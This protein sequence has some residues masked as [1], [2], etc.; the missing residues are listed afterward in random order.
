M[1]KK[2]VAAK[3]N[4]NDEELLSDLKSRLGLAERFSRERN[5]L[6]KKWIKDY[7]LE[8]IQEASIVD[9]SN[10]IHIPYIFSTIE[11]GLPTIFERIPTIILTQ[12]GKM[13][14]EF[15]EFASKI[16]NYLNEKLRLEEEIENVGTMFKLIGMGQLKYGWEIK[17]TTVTQ[18]EQTFIQTEEGT[19]PQTVYNE[20]QVP[21]KNLPFVKSVNYSSIFYS[22]ESVFTTDDEENEI[23]YIICR[24][25]KTQEEIEQQYEVKLNDED[26]ELLNLQEISPELANDS[27]LKE[28]SEGDLKRGVIY[29]YYGLLSKK[30]TDDPDWEADKNYYLVYNKNKILKK[31]EAMFKKPFLLIGNYGIPTEF[32]KFGEAKVLRELEQDVS[33]GRSRMMDIRDKYG[34]KVAI[35]EG[36]QVDEAALKRPADFTIMRFSGNQI[37]V[38]VTPPPIPEALLIALEQSRTDLQMASAQLDI[39]RGGQQST[40]KTAT[41]QT[42]FAQAAEKR[43]NRQK[44]KIGNLIKALAR[45]LLQLC[46][47]NWDEEELVKITDI[48]IEEIQQKS[49][50]EKLK[51]VGSLYDISIDQESVS[52]NRET[53]AAQAIA[54]YREVKD[55]PLVNR[56][57][58]LKEALKVGFG[59]QDFDRF[60]NTTLTPEQ[61]LQAVQTLIQMGLIPPELLQTIA[62]ALMGQQQEAEGQI[63]R[64]AEQT[65]TQITEKAMPGASQTQ[66]TSQ[67]R[68]SYKQ[69]GVPKGAQLP[70][71]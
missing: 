6:V 53:I 5:K 7:K 16:W 45:N 18:E 29:E 11:S 50:L 43:L 3:K 65:P 58:V 71:I 10:K 46:G 39:S 2:R 21:V 51:K 8:T 36:T 40:V 48:P 60:L 68:A 26:L 22:P 17:T 47:E 70:K 34:T 54:L 64:P 19:I 63:G 27:I 15:T 59:V 31:P 37:P 38:Y 42:I 23:P 33:L 66:I 13:D 56:Q 69:F 49:Y 12:R 20:Y 4:S 9:L 55:D 35:P 44:K 1:V 28:F 57:E 24:Y 67:N 41:G 61:L 62:Q 52:L 14:R 25:V 32:W 30:L